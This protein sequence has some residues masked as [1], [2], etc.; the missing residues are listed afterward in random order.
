MNIQVDLD[1]I[2]SYRRHADDARVAMLVRVITKKF[3]ADAVSHK[4]LDRLR[5]LSAKELETFAERT[6]ETNS[7]DELLEGMPE[8]APPGSG[9]GR[10]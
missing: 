2:E 1:N 5:D 8:I 7:I 10:R 9:H 6:I 4:V 3:G